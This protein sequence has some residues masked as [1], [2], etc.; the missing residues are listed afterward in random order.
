MQGPRYEL[1]S[2]LATAATHGLGVALL[3]AMLVESE[4]ERGE[5]QLVCD[6]P[7]GGARAYYLIMPDN[8][9]EKP[10]VEQFRRWLLAQVGQGAPAH[11]A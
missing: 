3:P 1:F 9:H 8:A 4:L 7:L 11:R 5:L 6:R 2:M 10:P